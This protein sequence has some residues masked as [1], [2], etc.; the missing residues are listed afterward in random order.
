MYY[1]IIYIYNY[2]YIL[3][4]IILT[5]FHIFQRGRSTTNQTS[6]LLYSRGNHGQPLCVPTLGIFGTRPHWSLVFLHPLPVCW[7]VE[8]THQPIAT[9]PLDC[10]SVAGIY[11]LVGGFKHVFF[12]F[13][14]G[15]SSQPHWRTHIFQDRYC[16]TNQ[17]WF[18]GDISWYISI[19]NGIITHL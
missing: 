2:I 8:A 19:V 16:T 18:I 4:I 10:C 12:N 6:L 14:Y 15:M 7:A 3:G 17:L 1:I 5:D 11:C 9:V 13:I